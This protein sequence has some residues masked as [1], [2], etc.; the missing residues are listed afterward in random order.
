[1]KFSRHAHRWPHHITPITA[2]S[3]KNC[4]SRCNG[5]AIWDW[6]YFSGM[7]DTSDWLARDEAYVR[8]LSKTQSITSRSARDILS[9]SC[10]Y[11]KPLEAIADWPDANLATPLGW[12]TAT[13]TAL[14]GTRYR[15]QNSYT[16]IHIF[17]C[18]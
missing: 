1:M 14:S 18:W 11:S 12:N 3:A 6:F 15:A 16:F 9:R 8:A 17:Y 5:Y 13:D 4:A 10:A 7:V 2:M